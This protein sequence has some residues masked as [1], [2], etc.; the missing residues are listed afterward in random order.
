MF[1]VVPDPAWVARPGPFARSHEAGRS[2]DVTIADSAGRCP[3]QQRIG[4]ACLADMG[5]DFD[6]F[7]P[8]ALA[9]T[10]QGISESAVA[11]RAMLRNAMG[12]GDLAAYSGEWWHFDGPGAG[13]N[14]PV[15]AAPVS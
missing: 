15:L 9:F 14:R 6:D 12:V 10:A 4:G 5:T 8:R 2:V 11:N 1:E 3:V 13:V 7:S